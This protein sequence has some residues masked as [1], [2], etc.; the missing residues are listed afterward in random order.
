MLEVKEV[1][2][3]YAQPVLNAV[4]FRVNAGEV[5]GIVGCSGAGK[6]SL[7]KIIAGLKDA[8]AGTVTFLGKKIVGPKAKL[9]PGYEDVQL[10]NQDFGLDIYHT[11]EENIREKMLHLP[12]T[13]QVSFVEELLDL[14][15][16]T[17]VRM[18]QAIVLSGGEQQRLSIAR[19][20][21]CEPKLLLLDEPF[22]HLDARLRLKITQ[23]LLRLKEVRQM[24]LILVSH[25]GEEMLSL[26]DTVI[27]LKKGKIRRKATPKAMYYAYK[28]KE[29]GELFGWVNA[30]Q[31]NGKTVYFRPDEFVVATA[32]SAELRLKFDNA[33]FCGGFYLNNFRSEDGK[34]VVLLDQDTLKDVEGI[35]IRKKN[36]KAKLE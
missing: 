18:Q 2:L 30:C 23:Y 20:L 1:S 33:L 36:K 11:V 21:A 13:M 6:T 28:S 24:A 34:I 16:L 7:L 25:N 17:A 29:E 26:A 15:E 3:A 27:Y 4:S 22:V 8:D 19:A 5:I 10:V 31:L 9:V 14:V 32:E 12:R 35:N